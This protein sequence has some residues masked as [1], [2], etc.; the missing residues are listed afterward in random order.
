MPVIGFM[1]AL[2]FIGFEVSRLAPAAINP[3]WIVVLLYFFPTMVAW[4]RGRSPMAVTVLNTS[5]GWTGVGWFVS[6]L[7]ALA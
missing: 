4:I 3:I 1:V 5:L 7:W 2:L 6:L